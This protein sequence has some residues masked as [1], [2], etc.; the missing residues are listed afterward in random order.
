MSFVEWLETTYKEDS[1]QSH[2]GTHVSRTRICF[3]VNP[4]AGMGGPLALKGTD[5][6]ARWEAMRRGA[7]PIAPQRAKRF[8]DELK[9]L[10]VLESILF[11]T[12]TGSMGEDLLKEYDVDY[13]VVNIVANPTIAADTIETV[14]RC[15]QRGIDLVVFCGGDG[16]ARDVALALTNKGCKD[17]PLLGI[18]AG[19]KMYSSIFAVNPEAAAQA[20]AEF[21]L[22]RKTNCCCE[23]EIVD[24]DEEAFRKNILNV[25]LYMVAQTLCSKYLVGVS[26]QPTLETPDEEEN[27]RAIA[28]H[29]LEYYVKP[30]TLIV[31]GP[32]TTTKAIADML[33]VEKT[34]LGVD[35][36]HDGRLVARDVDGPTLEKIVQDHLKS[37][38]HVL[39]IVSPIGGQGFIFGR[40]NQQITPRVLR[41]VGRN[42]ILVV[43]TRSKISRLKKLRIDTGD[44][45]LDKIFKGYIRVVVDYAEEVVMKIE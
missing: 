32:G 6:R 33:G 5:G 25:R 9:K 7:K 15:C 17:I 31:L 28:S 38:G 2:S 30:C 44:S 23:G 3:V 41:L 13:R 18:P 11:Y 36:V 29:I 12:A 1:T 10:G 40:G 21:I 34:L 45:E 27:R 19:V 22:S 24:I 4:I 14:M 20:T 37:G 8:L 43:A 39:I 35:V 16:T 26:K 42:N